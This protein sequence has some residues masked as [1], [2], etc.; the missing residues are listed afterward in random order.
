MM[1]RFSGVR[2]KHEIVMTREPEEGRFV[3]AFRDFA[4]VFFC[5]HAFLHLAGWVSANSGIPDGSLEISLG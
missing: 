5:G 1:K 2:F 3:M 4:E